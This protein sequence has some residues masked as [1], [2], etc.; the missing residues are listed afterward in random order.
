MLARRQ[1]HWESS[2]DER[3]HDAQVHPSA[4]RAGTYRHQVQWAAQR[5]SAVHP[6]PI[7]EMIDD[8]KDI[9]VKC[10]FC[11]TAY[12]FSVDELKELLKKSR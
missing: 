4:G 8:G 3:E 5:K 11:N 1:N 2:G 6:R 12:T 9:E 7:Q 10:H